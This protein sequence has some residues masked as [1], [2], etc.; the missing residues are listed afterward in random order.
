MQF[1][2]GK[3]P[4]VPTVFPATFPIPRMRGIIV[5]T[6]LAILASSPLGVLQEARAYQES[7]VVKPETDATPA[8]VSSHQPPAP[9]SEEFS[10]IRV[11]PK[12]RPIT[13]FAVVDATEGSE[14]VLD[15]EMILGVEIKG[16]T[17]AYPMNMING[18][19]REILNDE[20]GG[21][22]IA[23]TWCFLCHNGI[24]YAREVHGE[25]LTFSVSGLLWKRN[26][27][28]VDEESDSLWSHMLGRS[29]QG[30]FQ[31][32][33]LERLPVTMTTWKIW[34]SQHPETTVGILRRTSHRFQGDFYKAP[35]RFVIGFD[36][37]SKARAWGFADLI[38]QPVLNEELNG[39]PVLVLFDAKSF[40]A[41]LYSRSV[42]G[43][44]LTFT[45]SDKHLR[46]RETGRIWDQLTGKQMGTD[47]SLARLKRLPG[48]VSFAGSWKRFY[49]HSTFW[50]THIDYGTTDA[51][52]Q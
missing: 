41:S 6:L 24:V 20:V 34:K 3:H 45:Q 15:D 42:D 2:N 33:V 32:T 22:A 13:D 30:E 11:L 48:V 47:A 4:R 52:E 7:K 17:R 5:A 10:P 50:G 38:K 36:N 9:K 51:P 46:D 43:Q 21:K 1:N 35:Q 8:T 31:G 49:P 23:V 25:V 12:M 26:L 37:K 18:P 14:T 28:M 44:T 16:E 27:V 40:T 19:F 29:M 39:I